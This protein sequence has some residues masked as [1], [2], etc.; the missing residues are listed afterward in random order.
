ML[1][2]MA[3]EVIKSNEVDTYVIASLK[4]K[5]Q[6]LDVLSGKLWEVIRLNSND[7]KLLGSELKS[8]WFDQG[9]P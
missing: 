2:R 7:A 9:T 5:A 6:T 4:R 8:H 3:S 1:A